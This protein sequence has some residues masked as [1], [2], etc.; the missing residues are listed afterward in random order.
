MTSTRFL[1][2]IGLMEDMPQ[3][4]KDHNDLS[5]ALRQRDEVHDIVLDELKE[6]CRAQGMYRVH[7]RAQPRGVKKVFGNPLEFSLRMVRERSTRFP[8]MYAKIPLAFRDAL[9]SYLERCRTIERDSFEQLSDPDFES[10]IVR[11]TEILREHS[12]LGVSLEHGEDEIQDILRR[13]KEY[14]KLFIIDKAARNIKSR[15]KGSYASVYG[16]HSPEGNL[17]GLN[18]SI[19]SRIEN[20]RTHQELPLLLRDL[21]VARALY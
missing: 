17:E 20:Y 6:F 8:P 10:R 21:V 18:A 5:G 13:A 15:C 14:G 2:A 1:I 11:E 4:F 12:K 9:F 7:P 19:D 3:A 16:V